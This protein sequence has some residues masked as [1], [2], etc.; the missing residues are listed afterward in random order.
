[1]FNIKADQ[2]ARLETATSRVRS[3]RK[4]RF[5]MFD[6]IDFAM[7]DCGLSHDDNSSDIFDFLARWAAG[8]GL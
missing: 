3:Y 6:A 4:S 5:N 8:A 7:D 1:M 2:F